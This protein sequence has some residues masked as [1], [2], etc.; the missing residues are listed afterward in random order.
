MAEAG[1]SSPHPDGDPDAENCLKDAALTEAEHQGYT[2]GASMQGQAARS[3][4]GHRSAGRRDGEP[5]SHSARK[6]SQTCYDGM[7]ALNVEKRRGL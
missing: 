5:I 6:L 1:S 4:S 2:L 7:Y 3:D